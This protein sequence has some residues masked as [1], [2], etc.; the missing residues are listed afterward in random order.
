MAKTANVKDLLDK[1]TII[2]PNKEEAEVLVGEEIEDMDGVKKA[3]KTLL[4]KGIKMAVI[5][6]GPEGVYFFNQK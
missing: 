5:T 3:G 4:D 2:T 1:I 6:L